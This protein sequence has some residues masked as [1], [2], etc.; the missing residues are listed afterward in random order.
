MDNVKCP[1]YTF[2]LNLSN[3]TVTVVVKKTVKTKTNKQKTPNVTNYN[4][5]QIQVH[6]VHTANVGTHHMKD[7][8]GKLS[9]QE[10]KGSFYGTF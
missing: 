9:Q 2:L 8:C 1:Y 4:N 6:S 10:G 7:A 5:P 3:K